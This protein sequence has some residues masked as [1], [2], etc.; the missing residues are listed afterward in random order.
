MTF[1]TD[2]GEG[3]FHCDTCPEHIKCAAPAGAIAA[4]PGQRQPAASGAA[5]IAICRSIEMAAHCSTTFRMSTI[6]PDLAPT[7]TGPC[8]NSKEKEKLQ[9]RSLF[10]AILFLAVPAMAAEAPVKQDP[11]QPGA[12]AGMTIAECLSAMSGLNAL[13][14]RRVIVG[15][16]K[17]TES[18]ETVSYKFPGKVRD[19]ISHNL[20]V[21]MQVQQEGQAA[22][23]RAQFEIGKGE[24]IRT[25]SREAL[26]LDQRM[27][28]Y[29]AR[30][31]K[32]ELEHI[33]DADLKLDENDIPGSVLAVLWKIRDK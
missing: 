16:G 11:P 23:R 7:A 1:R 26:E 17:P 28:E 27:A 32:V 4:G 10:C 9:M 2:G 15:A 21:L 3:V 6:T 19:A 33:R 24:A 29:T 12:E 13:D 14:G 18:A 25:G 5:Q 30:P 31:C 8:P 22:N 20:F